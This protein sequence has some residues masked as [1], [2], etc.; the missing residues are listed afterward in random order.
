MA[1]SMDLKV[2]SFGAAYNRNQKNLQ[3]DVNAAQSFFGVMQSTASDYSVAKAD[4]DKLLETFN[5]LSDVSKDVL[6][7]MKNQDYISKEDW[8]AL[9]KDLLA[10][11]AISQQDYDLTR[12]SPQMIP[13]PQG[14]NSHGSSIL[15]E[16]LKG[17]LK[18]E[19]ITGWTGNVQEYLDQWRAMLRQMGMQK[20]DNGDWL[21]SHNTIN[22]YVSDRKST[23]LNSSH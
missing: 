11:G 17:Y 4:K 14:P 16:R 9:G 20:D 23:R 15:A 19:D 21:Y 22:T 6:R 1:I 18:G 2:S 8:G 5:K 3:N 7:K 13:M 12:V 10:V